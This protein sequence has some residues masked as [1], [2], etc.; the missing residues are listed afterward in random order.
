TARLALQ[1]LELLVGLAELRLRDVDAGLQA[2]L[3]LERLLLVLA[4][5]G[6][7]LVGGDQVAL[8]AEDLFLAA[9]ELALELA[10]LVLAAE[11]DPLLG[12]D[13]VAE[14]EDLLLLAVDDLAQVQ[15]LALAREGRRRRGHRGSAPR[16][17]E[18]AAEAR[19]VGLELLDARA[20][21]GASAR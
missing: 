10:D 21:G 6:D 2:L 8:Q 16:L 4:Q 11:D 9:G 13:L 12:V 18:V 7:G 17:L 15:E 20:G 3:A 1:V 5:A 19:H 14:V